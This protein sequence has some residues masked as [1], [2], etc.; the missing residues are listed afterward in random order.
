[1]T[2]ADLYRTCRFSARRLE[3]LQR[4][5]GTGDED[6]Q[7]AFRAGL[8]LPQPSPGKVADLK[9]IT[10][11]RQ[12]GR[13]VGRVHV[14]D[15]PLSDY[16]RYELA[17]YGENVAAGEDVLIAD[18]SLHPGLEGLAQDFAIFDSETVVLF[19]YDADGHVRGYEIA[20]DEATVTR[21][22]GQY[23]LAAGRAV[24]RADFVAASRAA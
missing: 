16:V 4:Y 22:I 8:P 13:Y 21:C 19:D 17:A 12:A 9:L 7:R 20:E 1:M 5:T 15:R 23:V 10:G 14:V 2:P 11:L 24:I 3:T 18:R 6:R